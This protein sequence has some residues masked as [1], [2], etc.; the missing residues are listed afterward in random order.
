MSENDLSPEFQ[1]VEEKFGYHGCTVPL[2]KDVI[3]K[4]GRPLIHINVGKRCLSKKSVRV[5]NKSL[6]EFCKKEHL[7][8][9]G[10]KDDFILLGRSFYETPAH[11]IANVP[12]CDQTDQDLLKKI[13][14]LKLPFVK[15][16]RLIEASKYSKNNRVYYKPLA[17]S[18]SDRKHFSVWGYLWWTTRNYLAYGD[19]EYLV[20]IH[21]DALL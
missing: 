13:K 1:K 20:V 15:K 6:Y 17:M 9:A 19:S 14:N 12:H 4:S 18:R 11:V 2:V 10:G 3:Q 16:L 21:P 7:I 8:F 5:L